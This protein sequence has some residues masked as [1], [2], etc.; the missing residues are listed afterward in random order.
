MYFDG[1]VEGRFVNLKSVTVADAEFTRNI[2]LDPDFEKFFPPLNNTLEQQKKWIE[3][4]QTK[5]GDYFFVVWDKKG[6]RIG[7]ISVYDIVDK[8]CESGR[9][10]IKGNAFQSTE[11]QMLIFKFA[12]ENLGM[13]TVLGYIF[14][15]NERAIRFNKQFGCILSEPELH[16][17]GH[18]MVKAI[19]TKDEVE[20][21][22]ERIKKMMY[23]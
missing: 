9:L 8:C 4:L 13:D 1:I 2:R 3:N 20:K 5:E 15:D 14:A 22:T 7:T 21:A 17:N 16:D 11:A 18:M 10:A 19:Y 12:F 6:K 23:R